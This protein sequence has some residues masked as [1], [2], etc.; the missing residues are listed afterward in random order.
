MR[1]FRTV[2][3]RS[4]RYYDAVYSWKDYG[5]EAAR[6]HDIVQR[7]NPFARTL[8]DVACGTGRHLEFFRAHYRVEGVDL[9]PELLSIA[10]KRLPGVPL[11]QA[12]MAHFDLGHT[13]DVV[14]VLFSAIAYVKTQERLDATVANL[15]RHTAPGGLVAFEPWILP[16]DYEYDTVHATF[17]DDSDLKIARINTAGPTGPVNVLEFHYLVGTPEG[18][19]AFT[20][21]HEIG[22]FSHEQYARALVRAGLTAHHDREGLMGRG[23]YVGV[24]PR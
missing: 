11:H 10:A 7:V 16:G 17:V 20:E 24:K 9:D 18:I 3:S 19:E 2:F 12:D 23:L 8:L 14:T 5:A 22:L 15:A 21:H 1:R 4:A 6:L 13:F